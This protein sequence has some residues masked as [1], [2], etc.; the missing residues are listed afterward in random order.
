MSYL[1]VEPFDG[2]W[3]YFRHNEFEVEA[4][5][6]GVEETLLDAASHLPEPG[7]ERTPRFAIV[8]ERIDDNLSE[9]FSPAQ[10]SQIVDFERYEFKYH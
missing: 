1:C 2:K 3:R 6:V 5:K 4:L 8:V 7:S 10:L 9:Q